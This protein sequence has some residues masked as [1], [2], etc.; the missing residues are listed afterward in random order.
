MA[1]M[2]ASVANNY[3]GQPGDANSLLTSFKKVL[4]ELVNK[5][6]IPSKILKKCEAEH[7]RPAGDD[8]DSKLVIKLKNKTENFFIKII[9]V[10]ADQPNTAYYD[11][12]T[13]K[14]FCCSV[15]HNHFFEI[16]K[17]IILKIN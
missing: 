14:D 15:S 1:L 16:I 17:T 4:P 7:C 11:N 3:Q 6:E 9:Q 10:G 12:H 5:T 2:P 8:D 13:A